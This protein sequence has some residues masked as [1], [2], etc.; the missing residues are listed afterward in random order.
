M[1]E[2]IETP[3]PSAWRVI[4]KGL[5]LLEHLLKNG[6][7]RC[8]DDARNHSH[9]LRNLDRFNYYEGTVDRG[10]GVREKSKQVVEILQDDERIREERQKA[11]QL[12]E[13][14]SGRGAAASS[15]GGSDGGGR[16]AGYGNSDVNWASSGNGGGGSRGYGES[17]IGSGGRD[18]NKGY[19]GRYGEG[20][21]APSSGVA[22]SPAIASRIKTSSSGG[23]KVK[24]VK[25]KE[26]KAAEAIAPEVDLFSFDTPASVPASTVDDSFDAFQ[27][28]STSIPSA[29]VAN[30]DFGDFQQIA[31]QSAVQFDAFGTAPAQQSFDAIGVA[32][33][34]QSQTI[35]AMNNAF[36]NMGLQN[37][38]RQMLSVSAMPPAVDNDDF[39]D[40]EDADLVS[41]KAAQKSSDPLS[42]LISL[43]GLSKNPKKEIKSETKPID[44]SLPLESNGVG[45][46]AGQQQGFL[47]QPILGTGQKGRQI[48]FK[49]NLYYFQFPRVH[50]LIAPLLLSSNS[51]NY[52]GDVGEVFGQLLESGNKQGG[53]GMMGQQRM[54][55]NAAGGV[56]GGNVAMM[57]GS[58]YQQPNVVMGQPHQGMMYNRMMVGQPQGN[59]GMMGGQP[60]MMQGN[61]GMMGGQQQPVGG[62]MQQQMGN[63]MGGQGQMNV[64]GGTQNQMPMMNSMM[65][66]SQGQMPQINNTMMGGSQ[67][68]MPHMNT[69]MGNSMGGTGVMGRQSGHQGF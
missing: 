28:A 45:M 51:K 19:A 3:R 41:V 58:M 33:S 10:L 68:Q 48:Q 43:D 31:P 18:S 30:D 8:V 55:L 4:F 25:K 65:S 17:G 2:A 21:T 38:H 1:W 40:F 37:Q 59:I 63:M 54:G 64:M 16:Y 20:D 5:T 44:F 47:Q 62:M 53:G 6:S 22:G 29:A 24:K 12:R 35:N 27:T 57:G 23:T 9:L 15:G 50:L 61:M 32:Q 56:V 49:N 52:A 7:E 67:G 42:K 13:K 60:G 34:T 69:M 11:R 26:K 66:G 46:I 14:F 36:G 39:G